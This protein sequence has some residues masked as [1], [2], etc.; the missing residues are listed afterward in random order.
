MVSLGF[1]PSRPG[2][3]DA[4]GSDYGA[5]AVLELGG[6]PTGVTTRKFR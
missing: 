6:A 4:F 2:L 1:V 3:V 5:F